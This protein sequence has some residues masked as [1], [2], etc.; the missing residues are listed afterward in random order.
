MNF[1][2]VKLKVYRNSFK[3]EQ[4]VEWLMRQRGISEFTRIFVL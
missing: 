2:Q 1:L 4:L 3:G